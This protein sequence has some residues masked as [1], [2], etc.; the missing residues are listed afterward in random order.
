MNL[1]KVIAERAKKTIYLDES[2]GRIIKLMGNEYSASDVFN[3][4]FNLACVNECGIKTPKLLEVSKIDGKWALIMEYIPGVTLKEHLQKEPARFDEYLNRFVDIQLDMHNYTAPR[5]A[6]LTEKMNRKIR[7]S[8]L[9]ATA[10]YELHTRLDGME[11]HTKL[12][13]GDFNPSNIVLT[14]KDDAYIIVWSHATQGNASADAARTY[15]LFQLAGKADVAEKYLDLFCKK[16]DTAR[17]YVQKWV[18]I[19]SASQMVK[20]KNE[21]RDF[22]LKWASVVDYE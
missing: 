19:V 12:C 7:Q 18:P 3:E 22:L 20:G 21:E 8:G 4:A 11:E 13:H 9:D 6:R 15:L 16:S 10:R 2:G 17:Q 5:L 1:G 14:D